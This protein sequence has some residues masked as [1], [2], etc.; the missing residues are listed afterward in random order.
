MELTSTYLG[1]SGW[2]IELG[3]VRV[4][5][6]PWLKGKLSFQPGSWLIEGTLKKELE[7]PQGINLVLLTQGLADHCHPPSLELIP[8]HIPVIGSVSASKV[9]R[10]IGFENVFELK[11]GECKYLEE[12]RIQATAG[13]PVPRLE[14]GYILEHPLGSFYLEPHGFLDNQIKSHH[15]DV[16]ITPVFNLRLPFA[17]KFIKGK[18][19]LPEL[20]KK[21]SPSTILAS[22]TGGDNIFTGVLN[23]LIKI[24]GSLEEVNRIIPT[25]TVFIEPEPGK[26]YLLTN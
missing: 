15:I 19:I 25:E 11:P 6:D 18:D 4:L 26:K 23:N 16:V 14:N 10:R 22:T 12:I 7:M 2:I 21:F 17:G 3:D 13:A 5:V 24:E 20:I 1:S 9:A 8:K